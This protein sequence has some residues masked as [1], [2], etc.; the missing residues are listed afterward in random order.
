MEYYLQS[1]ESK[2]GSRTVYLTKFSLKNVEET[3]TVPNKKFAIYKCSATGNVKRCTS[4]KK[5]KF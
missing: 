4:G 5:E 2:G 1:S 3:N